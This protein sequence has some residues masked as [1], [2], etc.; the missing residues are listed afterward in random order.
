MRNKYDD[1][2]GSADE[3]VLGRDSFIDSLAVGVESWSSPKSSTVVMIDGRWG[4]GKTSIRNFLERK[5]STSVDVVHFNPWGCLN[6]SAYVE[7]L[8]ESLGKT[9]SIGTTI[10]QLR[11][12]SKAVLL[13]FL[14][15]NIVITAGISTSISLV[16]AAFR[17][18]WEAQYLPRSDVLEIL[19]TIVVVCEV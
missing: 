12:Y 3:D 5:L 18:F 1:P 15:A 17:A 8:L 11:V 14:I 13:P 19:V 2:I 4:D 9:L 16:P 7:M 6:Q 10:A